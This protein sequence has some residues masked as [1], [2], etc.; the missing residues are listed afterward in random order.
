VCGVLLLATLLN[1]MDRQALAITLPELKRTYQ[2]AE[3]RAGWVEGCFGL[4]FAAG[5]VLFGF[6]ADRL[7]P[8][9]LYPAV[10]AGWSAAGVATGFAGRAELTGL[11]EG[12][13]DEPGTGVYRWL[14]GCR[15]LLGL[16]EAGHWPCALI[17][18]RRVLTAADRPLGNAVLQSGATAGAVLILVY[19]EVAQTL[20][21]GWP[22]VFWT[23]GA[24]GL[25]WVPL[26]LALI[27]PGDLDRPDPAGPGDPPAGAAGLGRRLAVLGVVVACLTVSWQFL[28]AWLPLLL[29]DHHGYSRRETRAA[30][31]GYFVAADIGCLIA[32]ALVLGLTRRGWAVHPARVAVFALFVGLSASA[33]VVPWLGGGAAMI[34]GLLVAGAGVLGLHPLY[35]ALSQDLPR[36]HM[37]VLSGALAAGG[38]VVSGVFQIVIGSRIEATKSYDTALVIAGLAP[39]VG[40]AALVILW[41]RP[42]PAATTG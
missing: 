40:L 6:L 28:R 37:G 25:L 2:L 17:T 5:S 4:A 3:A 7:G 13:G 8:R 38:W 20:G 30:A 18:A 19:A 23:V 31:I 15:T 39:L 34:A 1:Y 36:R 41:P 24:A 32:G 42:R 22:V 12:P 10:L 21:A 9:L 27:R 35:Y 16:F 14:L 26:W 29:E 33:A 11:L